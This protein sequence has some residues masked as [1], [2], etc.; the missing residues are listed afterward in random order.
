MSATT[1]V[2]DTWLTLEWTLQANFFSLHKTAK[3]FYGVG[4]VRFD[5]TL[6]FC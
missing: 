2:I 3:H 4:V 6:F 5:F 1:D